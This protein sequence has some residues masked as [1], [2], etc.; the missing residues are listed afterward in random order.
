MGGRRPEA[1]PRGS[2]RRRA[3]A[4]DS[5]ACH[6]CPRPSPLPTPR[7]RPARPPL[8]AP[9]PPLGS[10]RTKLRAPGEARP[11]SLRPGRLNPP[12]PIVR[13]HR[14]PPTGSSGR[15]SLGQLAR[16]GPAPGL[17]LPA[18]ATGWAPLLAL[19]GLQAAAERRA[20]LA[21]AL[22]KA[23]AAP[24]PGGGGREA[25]R[26][27]RSAALP[28]NGLSAPPARAAFHILP[29]RRPDYISTP[30]SR[31]RPVG[32]GAGGAQRA[33]GRPGEPRLR[34]FPRS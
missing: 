21:C 31:P 26:G 34:S 25:A 33:R 30:G 13:T 5:G 27:S 16:L 7:H 4:S 32:E 22:R 12:R 29:P 23:A 18:K 11:L 14:T 10:R 3:Q 15:T 2:R 6:F 1:G 28:G 19:R 8:T 20:A 9:R 24:A 17:R